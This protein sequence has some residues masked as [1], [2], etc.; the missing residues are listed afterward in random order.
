MN[1]FSYVNISSTEPP[2]RHWIE[3]RYDDDRRFCMDCPPNWWQRLWL[4]LLFGFHWD[5]AK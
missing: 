1:D 3:I 2:P 4:R 5:K